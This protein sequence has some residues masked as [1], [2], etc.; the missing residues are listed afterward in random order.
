MMTYSQFIDCRDMRCPMP[1][2][3]LKQSL[4]SLT[5][6]DTLHLIAT[7]AAS[8]QDFLAYIKLTEHSLKFEEVGEEIHYYVTKA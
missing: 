5:I 3:K 7:D 8:K 6:G 2:L 4:N 1:L